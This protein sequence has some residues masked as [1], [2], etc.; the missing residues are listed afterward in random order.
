[1]RC[2]RD[3]LATMPSLDVLISVSVARLIR[4]DPLPPRAAAPL[5]RSAPTYGSS[6]GATTTTPPS[7]TVWRRSI[8]FRVEA[9]QRAARDDD[10]AIDDRAADPRVPADA[11]ARHQDRIAR[12]CRSCAPA[13]SGTGCCRGSGCPTRCSRARSASRAPRRAAVLGEHELRRR[14]LRHV[15]AQRP[16]RI[17]QVELGVHLAQVHAAPRSTRRACRCRASTSPPSCSRRRTDRRRSR[18]WPI[19]D[20]MMFLPKS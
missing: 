6:S 11:H 7:V 19:S 5:R 17:V 10:V 8:F 1:M 3:E 15:G 18:P 2:P 14:R 12:S 13:R 4:V 16:L 20:G 9:D